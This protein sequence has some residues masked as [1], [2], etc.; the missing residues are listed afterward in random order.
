MTESSI[1]YRPEAFE[2]AKEISELV[3]SLCEHTALHED[4]K[5][6]AERTAY[7]AIMAVYRMG[8]REGEK[9]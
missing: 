9:A 8:F 4:I 1:V 6:H 5:D 2:M 7:S 3:K